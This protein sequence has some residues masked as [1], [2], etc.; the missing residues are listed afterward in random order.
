MAVSRTD[1]LIFGAGGRVGEA[2]SRLLPGYGVSISSASRNPTASNTRGVDVRSGSDVV[3]CIEAVRPRVVIYAAALSDP[4]RCERNP[5]VS[6]DVNVRGLRQVAAAAAGIG[7][8][9]VY[10]SSDYVFGA[11][12]NYFEDAQVAPLQVYGRHKSEAEQLLLGDGDNVVIR[13]PLLFG[14]RDFVGEAFNAIRQ[15]APLRCDGRRRYPI[16]LEH[17]VRVTAMT[18]ATN[19]RRGIYHAVGVDGVTKL[20]WAGYIAGL[21]AKPAPAVAAAADRS[22]APR[23]VDVVLSTR[24]PDMRAPAGTVWSATRARVAELQARL[25]PA[26]PIANA[27]S[28]CEPSAPGHA[29]PASRRCMS[30]PGRRADGVAE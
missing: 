19:A 27:G 7:S 6:Y 11:P 1:V 23:P 17:V 13:L 15:G 8:R 12:G 22:C 18:M 28:P 9:V 10:Y 3:E 30:R 4:D 29:G 24:H 21:L 20:E 25:D 14:S 16:P 5:S 26:H 2:L